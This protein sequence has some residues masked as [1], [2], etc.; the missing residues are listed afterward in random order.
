MSIVGKHV[1]KSGKAVQISDAT[2]KPTPAAPA[3]T[4]NSIV[5]RAKNAKAGT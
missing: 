3:P 5:K 2:T 1:G 4:L